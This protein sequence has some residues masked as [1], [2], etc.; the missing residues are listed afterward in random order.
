MS[1]ETTAKELAHAL[2]ETSEFSDLSAAEARIQL[3]PNAQQL[4]TEL[5]KSQQEIQ[6]AQSDGQPVSNKIQEVQL[7]QQKARQNETLQQFFQ[8]QQAFGRVMEKANKV[9]SRE[10]FSRS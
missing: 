5:E 3:D 10:L 4:I 6:K 9:I 1:V 8:A 2:K 7:L